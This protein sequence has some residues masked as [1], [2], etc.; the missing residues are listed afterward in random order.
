[1]KAVP[2]AFEAPNQNNS[3]PPTSNIQTMW[4]TEQDDMVQVQREASGDKQFIIPDKVEIARITNEVQHDVPNSKTQPQSTTDDSDLVHVEYH[5]N[6]EAKSVIS[7]EPGNQRLL[8][9]FME[10][11]QPDWT[12]KE[13]DTIHAVIDERVEATPTVP[14]GEE[15]AE[16]PSELQH[17]ISTHEAQP[18]W[19]TEHG[20]SVQAGSPSVTSDICAT[21]ERPADFPY[22]VPSDATRYDPYMEQKEASSFVAEHI[23]AIGMTD[24]GY[25]ERSTC[26]TQPD[27]IAHP[28]DTAELGDDELRLSNAT[29][30]TEHPTVSYAESISSL[31][32]VT[33]ISPENVSSETVRPVSTDTIDSESPPAGLPDVGESRV[34]TSDEAED[35]ICGDQNPSIGHLLSFPDEF[36]RETPLVPNYQSSSNDKPT[37]EERLL[38]NVSFV[39]SVVQS[40]SSADDADTVSTGVTIT[41][42]VESEAVPDANL[43]TGLDQWTPT[44]SDLIAHSLVDDVLGHA[45]CSVPDN[46]VD[47]DLQMTEKNVYHDSDST[48]L[49]NSEPVKLHINGDYSPSLNGSNH[50]ISPDKEHLEADVLINATKQLDLPSGSESL[51]TTPQ[52]STQNPTDA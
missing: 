33:G 23:P 32:V 19:P 21:A 31:Q 4:T 5:A 28:S 50:K 34:V 2:S 1:M 3:H 43:A 41:S 52:G 48:L 15:D 42:E 37:D 6:V 40:N 13:E 17:E 36:P 7:N 49:N 51:D 39:H 27:L 46:T 30:I 45:A 22:D 9:E 16:V 25:F 38:D 44:T 24:M 20:E 10:E 14:V 26:E 18:E 8:D 47:S 12:T 35:N 29:N 11:I